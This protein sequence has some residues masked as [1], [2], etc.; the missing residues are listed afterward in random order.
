MFCPFQPG[1]FL[2]AFM[3][4]FG[5]LSCFR[6]YPLVAPTT[7]IPKEPKFF[8]I[9]RILILFQRPKAVDIGCQH[10][11]RGDF[12]LVCHIR[13]LTTKSVNYIINEITTYR[14]EKIPHNFV[15]AF[16]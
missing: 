15:R 7:L 4:G 3:A 10:W 8:V 13:L 16:A 12:R 1:G 5:G 2:P 6:R 11:D 9:V 14:I